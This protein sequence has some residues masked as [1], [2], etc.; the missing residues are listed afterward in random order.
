M[1]GIAG[2]VQRRTSDQLNFWLR[3]RNRIQRNGITSNVPAAYR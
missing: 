3:C 1:F 2:T